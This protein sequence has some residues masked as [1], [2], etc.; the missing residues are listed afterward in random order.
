ME[1]ISTFLKGLKNKYLVNEQ[2][3][4]ITAIR[5]LLKLT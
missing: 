1:M 4:V 2:I 3:I 5:N